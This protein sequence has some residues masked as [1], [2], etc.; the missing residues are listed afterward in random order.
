MVTA[1]PWEQI[2][3]GSG[4]WKLPSVPRA[5]CLTQT[6]VQASKCELNEPRF[7]SLDFD[8]VLN[9]NNIEGLTREK[10]LPRWV[11]VF[12]SECYIRPFVICIKERLCHNLASLCNVHETK[13]FI[14]SPEVKDDCVNSKRTDPALAHLLTSQH[15]F[16]FLTGAGRAAQGP[17]LSA[18][19]TLLEI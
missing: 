14:L 13:V 19:F 7:R 9:T 10:W 12:D 11:W 5:H 15:L 8:G 17:F 3:S 18:R 6:T 16:R 2:W 1:F 4:V